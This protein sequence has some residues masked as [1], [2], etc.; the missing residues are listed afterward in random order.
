MKEGQCKSQGVLLLKKT[1]SIFTH[2]LEIEGVFIP[3]PC[4]P[5]HAPASQYTS[6]SAF[7]C[8]IWIHRGDSQS[9]WNW[10]CRHFL[11]VISIC[12]LAHTHVKQTGLILKHFHNF[13]FLIA[14][15]GVGVGS[16]R[17]HARY[18]VIAMSFAFGLREK[19]QE[20]CNKLVHPLLHPDG[21]T[22][23]N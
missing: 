23:L 10:T 3:L 9:V 2:L 4:A 7:F 18:Y 5:P 19:F 20:V 13:K 1:H 12:S 22:I 6:R 15:P 14:C 16:K 21:P 17:R 11:N 8:H